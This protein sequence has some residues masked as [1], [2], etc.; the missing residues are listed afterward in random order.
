MKNWL[1]SKPI[2]CF[3]L[4]AL[5]IAL[6]DAFT[7]VFI[8]E[9]YDP[10]LLIFIFFFIT[11]FVAFVYSLFKKN[12]SSSIINKNESYTSKITL[13]LITFSAFL[14]TVFGIKY[15]GAPI[16]SLI[17]HCLIPIAT[18]FLASSMLNEEIST[19]MKTGMTILLTSV[20]VF[21]FSSNDITNDSLNKN[22]WYLGVMLAVLSAGLTSLSSAYQKKLVNQHYRSDQILF[23]RFIIPTILS[24]ILVVISDIRIPS[25]FSLVKISIYGFFFFTT[26]LLLLFQG[27]IRSSL[28]RFSPFNIL[29]P[30]FTFIVGSFLLKNEFA[31]WSNP[32]VVLGIFGISV[33]Y[34]VFEYSAL[35]SIIFPK[36]EL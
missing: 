23:I 12:S 2:I 32:L 29:V 26:P 1:S 19:T 35:K 34:I 10:L 18:L 31:K 5:L 9:D 33:G 6:R 8:E 16:F 21:L 14:S 7:Q 28:G 36:K 22:Q 30:A 11:T 4:F 17:E 13:G 20:F 3:T 27:F 25:L 24:G 15:L